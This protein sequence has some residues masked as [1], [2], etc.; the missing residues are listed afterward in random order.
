MQVAVRMLFPNTGAGAAAAAA[1]ADADADADARHHTAPHEWR[2]RRHS[3]R[4]IARS[5]A[6]GRLLHLFTT[7][8]YTYWILHTCA[9]APRV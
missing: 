3:R 1:A 8:V 9:V 5:R 7:A 6:F 2:S 4:R